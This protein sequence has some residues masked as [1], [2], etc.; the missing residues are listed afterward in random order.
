MPGGKR[1]PPTLTP[2][3]RHCCRDPSRPGARAGSAARMRPQV[4]SK[5]RR[6][7]WRKVAGAKASSG[8]ALLTARPGWKRPSGR[9]GFASGASTSSGARQLPLSR[10]L[11]ALS[12][13]SAYSRYGRA[14]RLATDEVEKGGAL[15]AALATA[16]AGPDQPGGGAGRRQRTHHVCAR[17]WWKQRTP[18]A[19]RGEPT[20]AHST[21]GSAP[22]AAGCGRPWPWP[23]PF[24]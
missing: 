15:E 3:V 18:L 19:I 11:S 17:H 7:C 16:A 22:G 24:W 13:G 10:R 2:A 9:N 4:S 1:P 5:A 20:S 14:T 23:M 21:S 12:A 8:S 6:P